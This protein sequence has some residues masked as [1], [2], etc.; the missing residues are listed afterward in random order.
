MFNVHPKLN[1]RMN[2]TVAVTL[3]PMARL[4]PSLNS[5]QRKGG[6]IFTFLLNDGGWNFCEMATSL[7]NILGG[8]HRKQDPME[9]LLL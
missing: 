1:I 2:F 7:R 4:S 9:P 3:I 8:F 6:S 5:V